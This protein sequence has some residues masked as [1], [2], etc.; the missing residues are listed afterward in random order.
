MDGIF[1]NGLDLIWCVLIDDYH[2]KDSDNAYSF[3][4]GCECFV[5]PSSG[6]E[7]LSPL[8]CIIGHGIDKTQPDIQYWNQF[9][10]NDTSELYHSFINDTIN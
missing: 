1:Y 5:F 2:Q 7:C 6:G 10:T 3:P 8:D 9:M 4:V